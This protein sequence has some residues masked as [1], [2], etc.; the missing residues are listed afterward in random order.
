M[1]SA[2]DQRFPTFTTFAT[3]YLHGG[4]LHGGSLVVVAGDIDLATAPDRW[5]VGSSG[6]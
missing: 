4:S 1:V 2:T 6:E 5:I 3:A